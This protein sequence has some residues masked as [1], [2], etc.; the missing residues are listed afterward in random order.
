MSLNF[1]S[2]IDILIFVMKIVELPNIN[3]VK[4]RGVF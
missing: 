2:L 1:L 4:K 3:F